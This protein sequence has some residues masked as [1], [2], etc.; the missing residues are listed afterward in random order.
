MAS[1]SL[2][3]QYKLEIDNLQTGETVRVNHDGCEAGTD[4]RRRL[5]ITRPQSNPNTVIAYCHNCQNSAYSTTGTHL[6]FRNAKHDGPPPSTTTILDNIQ[7]PSNMIKHLTDWP[8]A[9]HAWALKNKLTQA[10]LI[11]YGIEYDP[12][13]ERVYLPRYSAY[14]MG[15]LMGYQLR[16]VNTQSIKQPKYLTVTHSDDKGYTIFAT[17]PRC[18]ICVLVEDLVSGIH[19]Y[20]VGKR[21]DAID[22]Y[23]VI[24]NYGTKVNLEACYEAAQFETVVVWLD[25]DSTHVMAQ[26]KTMQ[27][28][29]IMINPDDNRRRIL[30]P[31][32]PKHY[33]PEDIHRIIQGG[34]T[35]GFN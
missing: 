26:A 31:T 34:T 6:Q 25:N 35:N 21:R 32:D 10:R 1:I 17:V 23:A 16:N 11:E 20:D 13:S 2:L 14:P 15:T 7:S 12:N 28:T 19:V 3:P 4:V 24:V 18:A 30:S 5:Y 8:T 33:Q 29:I 27:R 9:A 22:Q